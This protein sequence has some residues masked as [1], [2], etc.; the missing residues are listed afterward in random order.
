MMV[1]L[2]LPVAMVPSPD[3]L[4]RVTVKLS[5][6]SKTL[7]PFTRTVRVLDV[8]PAAKLTVPARSEEHTSE[9]QS[10]MSISYAVFCLKKKNNHIMIIQIRE[11]Y[12]QTQQQPQ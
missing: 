3:G 8:W 4:E 1:P 12:S 2:A 10:L 5:L 7:S 9:L 11:R 6:A